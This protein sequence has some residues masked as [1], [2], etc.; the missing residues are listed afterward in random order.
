MSQM[1]GVN[2]KLFRESLASEQNTLFTESPRQERDT[3]FHF[4]TGPHIKLPKVKLPHPSSSLTA[5][6]MESLYFTVALSAVTW[7]PL[8]IAI[9]GKT[10]KKKSKKLIP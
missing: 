2:P 7:V 4:D 3:V 1:E 5:K 9:G 8:G 10:I 6:F